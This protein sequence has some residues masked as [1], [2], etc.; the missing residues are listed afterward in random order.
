MSGHPSWEN[1][2]K[3]RGGHT[4]VFKNQELAGKTKFTNPIF[5]VN[6]TTIS[7]RFMKQET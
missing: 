6:K 4:K 3:N 5:K 1:V 7:S 2:L